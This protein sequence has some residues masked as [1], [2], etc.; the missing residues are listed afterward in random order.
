VDFEYLNQDL[1]GEVTNGNWNKQALAV[2]LLLLH[3]NTI[4]FNAGTP[5]GIVSGE[6]LL[7][8]IDNSL[9]WEMPG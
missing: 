4:S 2:V 9:E 3:Q 5:T 1:G 6:F 7:Q 8:K